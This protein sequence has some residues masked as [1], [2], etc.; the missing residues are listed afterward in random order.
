[1]FFNANAH[2]N[3]RFYLAWLKRRRQWRFFPIVGFN[4]EGKS[5]H[6]AF[7]TIPNEQ[8][9]QRVEYK[10]IKEAKTFIHFAF[11]KSRQQQRVLWININIF[12]FFVFSFV[13]IRLHAKHITTQTERKTGWK[14][15]TFFPAI[16]SF[17]SLRLLHTYIVYA[18]RRYYAS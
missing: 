11:S 8:S 2:E 15:G 13:S 9:K 5:T 10:H 4:R 7:D 16:D 12:Y 6:F 14:H 17:S 1:M 18:L 3:F